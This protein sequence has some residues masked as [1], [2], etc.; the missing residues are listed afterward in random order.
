M[1]A[2]KIE[3]F[4]SLFFGFFETECCYFEHSGLELVFLLPQPLSAVITG[5]F[6]HAW[7]K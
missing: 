3:I 2:L 1:L 5:M 4:L 6:D 7:L